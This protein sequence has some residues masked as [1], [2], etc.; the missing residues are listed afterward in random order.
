MDMLF[1]LMKLNTSCL[2]KDENLLEVYDG[3]WDR[4]RNFMKEGFDSEPMYNEKYL[5]T[6]KEKPYGKINV[7]F[8]GV[9]KEGS[10]Y[11]RFLSDSNRFCF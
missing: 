3:I 9:L 4:V 11:V 2:I 5:K 8:H 7:N 10:H 6:K 1:A